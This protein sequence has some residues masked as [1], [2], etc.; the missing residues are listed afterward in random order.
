VAFDIARATWG[1]NCLPSFEVDDIQEAYQKI[2][3]LKCDVAFPL[4]RI[5][6]NMV[7]EFTDSEGNDIEVYAKAQLV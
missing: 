7:F 5:G 3:D 6:D 1:D 4:K 2:K